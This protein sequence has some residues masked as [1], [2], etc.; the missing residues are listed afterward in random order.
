MER[1]AAQQQDEDKADDEGEDGAHQAVEEPVGVPEP[2]CGQG[3]N[4]LAHDNHLRQI[5][6]EGAYAQPWPP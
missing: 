1:Q 3:P 2:G 5:D 4:I 6:A